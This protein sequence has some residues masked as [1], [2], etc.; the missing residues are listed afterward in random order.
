MATTESLEEKMQRLVKELS[1]SYTKRCQQLHRLN[2]SQ[3]REMLPHMDGIPM[4][5][6]EMVN[7]ILRKEFPSR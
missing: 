7:Q 3:L 5:R 4:N 1:D 2:D 6:R